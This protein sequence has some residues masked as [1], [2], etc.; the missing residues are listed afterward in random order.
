[1]TADGPLFLGLDLST[2][3]LKASLLDSSL[4]LL[5]EVAVNFDKDLPHYGTKGGVHLGASGSGA[6]YSPVLCAVEAFDKLA[7]KILASQWPT[8]RIAAVSA[9]GQQ[10][11]SVYWSREA[12]D[13]INSA[14]L[15]SEKTLVSQ[16]DARAFSRAIVP[17]WQ[18]SS[19][20][21]ECREFESHV[22]GPS[23]LARLTGSRAYER[24]TGPQILKF[25]KEDPE[26]YAN[27]SRVSLVSSFVTTMLC[28]DGEIKAIDESDACGMNLWDLSTSQR[29]WNEALLDLV[30]GGQ[31][32]DLLQKLGTVESDGARVVGHIGA[33]WQRRLG[34]DAECIV[35]PATGDNPA[36]LLS[37]ALDPKEALVSLGTS[38]TLLIP[39]PRY[40]TSEAYHVFYHPA[41]VATPNRTERDAGVGSDTATGQGDRVATPNHFFNMLVYKNGSLAR[42]AMRDQWSNASWEQFDAEVRAG[43]PSSSSSRSTWKPPHIG[44]YWLKAEI[45]PPNA[46][47]THL[48][49]LDASSSSTSSDSYTRVDNLPSPKSHAPT[50]ISS[51]LLSFRSRVGSIL[52]VAPGSHL[53]LSRI[54]ASGGASANA[55]LLQTMSDILGCEMVKP[56]GGE[57][58]NACSVGAAY[59]ARW[60]WERKNVQG[61]EWVEFERCI[62]EARQAGVAAGT[63]GVKVLASPDQGRHAAWEGVLP[64]WTELEERALRGD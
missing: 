40:N 60:A 13:L 3:A 27:T 52:G 45:I 4:H 23:E 32:A 15:D 62:R 10:H 30:S 58:G 59:K 38:D 64:V 41:R 33:Y 57:Q 11:A 43:W 56:T 2:Q 48:Y 46:Q 16:V 53:D 19:T 44:F 63:G 12:S 24:F 6:V 47:G 17:N 1:M 34:F 8:G 35:V 54:Y 31:G 22:G 5:S 9:A 39:T 61:R 28:L 55:T 50:I 29:G 42:E 49:T 21:I 26:A 25:R 18:D 37:F 14:S 36:T 20:T 51:Q 7:D